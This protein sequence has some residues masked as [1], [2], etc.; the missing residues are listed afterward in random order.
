MYDLKSTLLILVEVAELTHSFKYLS[1]L[2]G[3]T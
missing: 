3:N 1:D 2:I